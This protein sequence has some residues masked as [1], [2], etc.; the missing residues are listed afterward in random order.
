MEDFTTKQEAKLF[1]ALET[2]L[3][4]SVDRIGLPKKA[5][6]KQL[7]KAKQALTDYENFKKR[8]RALAG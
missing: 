3:T 2:L 5:T 6:V 1:R 7:M 4:N 8:Y